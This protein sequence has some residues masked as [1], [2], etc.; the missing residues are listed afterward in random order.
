MSTCPLFYTR[1]LSIISNVDDNSVLIVEVFQK[2]H[3]GDDTLVG[4]LTDTIGVV[5]AR[6][7]D[8]STQIL[9]MH[10]FC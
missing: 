5:L 3:I 8:G 7:T 1:K 4:S 9:L 6:L 2:H 10:V